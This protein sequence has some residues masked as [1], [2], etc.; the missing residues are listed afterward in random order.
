MLERWNGDLRR[1]M[2]EADGEP[3]RARELL[4]EVPRIGPTGADIFCREVQ[5]V[6]PRMRPFADARVREAAG[7][8]GLPRT[9]RALAA[10]VPVG[11]FARFADGL[12]RASLSPDAADRQT[13][14]A[15]SQVIIDGLPTRHPPPSESPA[16]PGSPGSPGSST[17]CMA[18]SSAEAA[19]PLIP[20]SRATT[21]M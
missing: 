17:M 13:G 8:L 7:S 5:A 19:P 1:L 12:V 11:D 21:E 20:T 3:A 14:S 16:P 2:D 15:P 18:A 6:W 10:L 9:R 4:Q